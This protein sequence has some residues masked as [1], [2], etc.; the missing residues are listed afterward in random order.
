MGPVSASAP[1][2]INSVVNAGLMLDAGYKTVRDIGTIGN[3]AVSVRDAIA[4][5]KVRGRR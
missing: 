2:A 4:A 1:A 3:A 5:G